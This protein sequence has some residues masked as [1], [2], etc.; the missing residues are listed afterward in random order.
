[1]GAMCYMTAWDNSVNQIQ[2]LTTLKQNKKTTNKI[3][4]PSLKNP[5]RNFKTKADKVA[6]WEEKN[7]GSEY[8]GHCSPTL[9]TRKDSRER[10]ER[11]LRPD[12][13]CF[14]MLVWQANLVKVSW[15]ASTRFQFGYMSVEM[16]FAF[17][18]SIFSLFV[19]QDNG[20]ERGCKGW[21][22]SLVEPLAVAALA[23]A[24]SVWKACSSLAR[25]VQP[26][27]HSP[28]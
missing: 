14:E 2:S 1:M 9:V 21:G 18:C 23:A 22:V 19:F 11:Q 24:A 12:C 10:K 16:E 27:W 20:K 17:S 25:A 5:Q 3:F 6:T 28:W 4:P 15:D 8:E 7:S 13:A 26:A